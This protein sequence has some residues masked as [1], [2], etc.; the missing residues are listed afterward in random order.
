MTL[1]LLAI[2]LAAVA[3]LVAVRAA[4]VR[5]RDSVDD[6]MSDLQRQGRWNAAAAI[7]NALASVLIVVAASWS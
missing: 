6:F 5:V 1:S 4:T 7:L 2:V 3:A